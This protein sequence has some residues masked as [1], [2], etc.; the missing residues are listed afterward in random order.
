MDKDGSTADRVLRALLV[1]LAVSV[2]AHAS[3]PWYWQLAIVVALIVVLTGVVYPAIRL[4]L[5]RRDK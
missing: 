4:A 3:F 2:G 5:A 1:G